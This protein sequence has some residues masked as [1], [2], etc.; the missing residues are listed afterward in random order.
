MR[1]VQPGASR[2]AAG[3][4]LAVLA[5]GVMVA[6]MASACTEKLAGGAACPSLCPEVTVDVRDTVIEGVALDSSV[7]GYPLPGTEPYLV[8]ASRGDTADARAVI[9]FDTLTAHYLQGGKDTTVTAVDSAKLTLKVFKPGSSAPTAVRVEAYDV[10][11][12]A[13]D[14]ALSAVL[15]LFR[16]DRFLGAVTVGGRDTL[17]DTLRVPLSNTS[18][19][20]KI[21]GGTRLRVGLRVAGGTG[22]LRLFSRETGAAGIVSYRPTPDTSVKTIAVGANSKTPADLPQVAADLTDYTVGLAGGSPL[23]ATIAVGGLPS[24]RAFLQFDLPSRIVD[25]AQVLR[26]TLILTQTRN[27]RGAHG[28]TVVVVPAFV[29][30]TPRVTDIVRVTGLVTIPSPAVDSFVVTPVD[31]G[32]R[33]LEV[34]RAVNIWRAGGATGVQRALVL[35]VNFEG[36]TPGEVLFYSARAPVGLRPRIRLSYVPQTEL[37]RP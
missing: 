17:P 37:G 26:A 2:W 30:A 3:S 8:V 10:D 23:P 4:R 35:R 19:L 13:A 11:T 5:V 24:R 15:P 12:T 9:R 34:V 36:S 1:R 14:T 21:T 18:V 31:S 25:S 28:D 29:E 16:P 20:A 6:A 22:Q 33:T 7:V 27:P 32:V